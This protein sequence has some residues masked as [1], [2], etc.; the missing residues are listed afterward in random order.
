MTYSLCYKLSD[1]HNNYV[2]IKIKYI[3]MICHT[4]DTIDHV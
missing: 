4:V 2:D 1:I 3:I